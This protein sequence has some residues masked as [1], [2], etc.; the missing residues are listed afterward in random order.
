MF[1]ADGAR[2]VTWYLGE[3][4][5]SPKSCGTASRPGIFID[6]GNEGLDSRWC[7]MTGSTLPS[8][9][10]IVLRIEQVWAV[11]SGSG[12]VPKQVKGKPGVTGESSLEDVYLQKQ[13]ASVALHRTLGPVG[14]T[15]CMSMRSRL[16]ASSNLS[17]QTALFRR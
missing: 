14:T 3:T 9:A 15:V 17:S 13:R 16:L 8:I 2:S 12:V 11:A 5:N 4:V 1:E 7:L 10:R 6:V